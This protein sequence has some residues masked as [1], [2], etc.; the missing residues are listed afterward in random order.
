MRW[1]KERRRE[2]EEDHHVTTF[3]L[4]SFMKLLEFTIWDRAPKVSL[5]A[6]NLWFL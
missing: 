2:D 5:A 6:V 3:D 1:R 4:P